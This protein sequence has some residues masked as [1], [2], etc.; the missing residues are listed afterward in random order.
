MLVVSRTRG[1]V[2]ALAWPAAVAYQNL[3]SA[4]SALARRAS[5]HQLG[6]SRHSLLRHSGRATPRRTPAHRQLSAQEEATAK[7]TTSANTGGKRWQG[8][9]TSTSDHSVGSLFMKSETG[10]ASFFRRAEADE[11]P[12]TVF[13]TKTK[14]RRRTATKD[15]INPCTLFGK[16]ARLSKTLVVL[17]VLFLF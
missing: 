2:P 7:R 10:V 11:G 15:T 8:G 5:C 1:S 9:T 3:R 16:Y 14:T 4:P 13:P 12:V 17:Y 6:W